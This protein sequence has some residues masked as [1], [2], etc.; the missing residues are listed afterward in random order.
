MHYPIAFAH[1]HT[2]HLTDI[3]HTSHIYTQQQVKS[4][5]HQLLVLD[6]T[7]KFTREILNPPFGSVDLTH[8]FSIRLQLPALSLTSTFAQ[9][10]PSPSHAYPLSPSHLSSPNSS[11]I[12]S[13]TLSLSLI[14][15][16]NTHIIHLMLGFKQC[17][18]T[19]WI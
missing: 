16:F 17:T 15:L 6:F 9:S 12:D 4:S 19:V 11:P 1:T 3:Q 10:S 7:P 5:A 2:T 14:P 8:F 18:R 13:V